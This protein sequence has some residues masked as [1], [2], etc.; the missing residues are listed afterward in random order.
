VR[1][2]LLEDGDEVVDLAKVKEGAYVLTVTE[3]GMGKR[4]PVDAFREQRRGGKGVTAMIL[5]EKSG[6][7]ACMKVVGDSE[8]LMF[9]RDDGT[10]IRMGVDQ[11][12]VTQNRATQGVRLMR[13]EEGSRVAAVEIL[14]SV[15]E[16][17]ETEEAS[18]AQ[19]WNAA[20]EA[21]AAE[22]MGEDA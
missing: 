19:A 12:S 17:P 13:V 14:P 20:L 9:I 4:T 16:L 15:E 8:D 10:V 5:S 3:N 21:L 1:S 22:D 18:N 6:L 11:V 2:M 7:L